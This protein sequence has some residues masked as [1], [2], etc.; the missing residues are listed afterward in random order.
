MERI[1]DFKWNVHFT[2]QVPNGARSSVNM[3]NDFNHSNVINYYYC[4]Y[5]YYYIRC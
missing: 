4:Y 2:I 3:K 5:Y 1:V